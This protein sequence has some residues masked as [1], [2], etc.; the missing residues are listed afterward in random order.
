M[1][2]EHGKRWKDGRTKLPWTDLG[3]RTIVKLACRR[4]AAKNACEPHQP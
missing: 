1:K 4:A 2:D 3:A